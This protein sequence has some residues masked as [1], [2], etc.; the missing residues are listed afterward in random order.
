MVR[1][2]KYMCLLRWEILDSQT[3]QSLGMGRVAGS[4]DGNWKLLLEDLKA[5]MR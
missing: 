5:E 4:D 3:N 2:Y 1:L